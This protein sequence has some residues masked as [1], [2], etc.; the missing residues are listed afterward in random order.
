MTGLAIAFSVEEP[1]PG[2]GVSGLGPLRGRRPGS[3]QGEHKFR[4]AS[5]L[6][7]VQWKSRHAAARNAAQNDLANLVGRDR[8]KLLQANDCRTV[9][10]TG[11]VRAMTSRAAFPELVLLPV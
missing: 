4:Q 11:P 5:G 2:G 8:A 9:T 7:R 6:L 3:P 1:L 10:A